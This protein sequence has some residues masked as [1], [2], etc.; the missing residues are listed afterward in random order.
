MA[1]RTERCGMIEPLYKDAL[2]RLYQGD[3]GLTLPHLQGESPAVVLTDA[4]YFLWA[5][6]AET[7]DKDR[8]DLLKEAEWMSDVFMTTLSWLPLLR[9]L[10]P[11]IAFFFAEPHYA[12]MY[13]RVARYLKWPLVGWWPALRS[14]PGADHEEYLLAF[15]D[16]W[17]RKYPVNRRL[18]ETE[19]PHAL[20]TNSY[21]QHK[22]QDMLRIIL[23]ASPRGL[24]LD[25]FCGSGSTLLAA[26][27]LGVPS[28]GIELDEV[29]AAETINRLMLRQ[30]T[31]K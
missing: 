24:V 19:V 2:V 10:K 18:V 23:E 9:Y 4:P 25:P 20:R 28:I 22:S 14:V 5:H 30:E 12:S 27:W 1:E 26:R 15:A 8:L 29:I 13:L 7:C 6:I 16:D 31:T 11:S 3:A 17:A 21:G